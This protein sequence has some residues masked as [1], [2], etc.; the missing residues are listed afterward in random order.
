MH[1]WFAQHRVRLDVGLVCFRLK[2]PMEERHANAHNLALELKKRADKCMYEAKAQ[3][4]D[5]TLVS[6]VK[7]KGGEL[8]PYR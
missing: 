1:P 3:K 7:G 5:H 8:I 4:S 2:G 6:L